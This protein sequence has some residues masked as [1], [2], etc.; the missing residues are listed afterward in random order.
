M[1]APPGPRVEPPSTDELLA[2][3]EE[4]SER[5]GSIN[6]A[7]DDIG[8]RLGSRSST[9][10]H[11]T[12]GAAPPELEHAEQAAFHSSK[13]LDLIAVQVSRIDALAREIGAVEASTAELARRMDDAWERLERIPAMSVGRDDAPPVLSPGSPGV[14]PRRTPPPHGEAITV[15]TARMLSGRPGAPG[16]RLSPARTLGLAALAAMLLVTAGAIALGGWNSERSNGAPAPATQ[17][18]IASATPTRNE[19]NAPITSSPTRASTRESRIL[20]QASPA[21]ESRSSPTRVSTPTTSTSIATRMATSTPVPSP[22]TTPPAPT[23]IRALDRGVGSTRDAIERALGPL[24]YI[25]DGRSYYNGGAA[26]VR[27]RGGVATELSVD[28][29]DDPPPLE[30]VN[31]LLQRLRPIDARLIDA[32]TDG[33]GTLRRSHSSESI[34]EEFGQGRSYVERIHFSPES[35]GILGFSVS[36]E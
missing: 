24:E 14:S 3:V 20:P 1:H 26:S 29:G 4:L 28:F 6:A 33:D 31:G 34:A 18:A 23:G 16:F 27:Y 35:G 36:V 21:D 2:R 12:A 22:T 19:L 17:A 5:L 25:R 13:A 11:G 32:A 8:H 9:N 15:T 10:V 7:Q 30:S